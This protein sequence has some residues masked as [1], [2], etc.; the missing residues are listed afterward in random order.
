MINLKKEISAIKASLVLCYVIVIL[1]PSI[2]GI[3]SCL[4]DGKC[5]GISMNVVL[6]IPIFNIAY[7]LSAPLY[8]TNSLNAFINTKIFTIISIIVPILILYYIGS[9]LEGLKNKSGIWSGVASVL[10]ASLLVAMIL[11]GFV[12]WFFSSWSFRPGF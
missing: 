11:L 6:A 9:L 5:V 2:P 10:W 1:L 8:F 7:L 12:L 3:F 4:A